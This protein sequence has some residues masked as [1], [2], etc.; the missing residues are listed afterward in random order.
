[1]TPDTTPKTLTATQAQSELA[2]LGFFVDADL[3][4]LGAEM[5]SGRL[6]FLFRL[7]QP[8][9]SASPTWALDRDSLPSLLATVAWIN[10]PE[11]VFDLVQWSFTDRRAWSEL[12]RLRR[13]DPEEYHRLTHPSH[14]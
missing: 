10:R 14:A 9:D 1:M 5:R 12:Q 8:S 6:H 4:C 3:E 2:R 11:P 7:A 13:D